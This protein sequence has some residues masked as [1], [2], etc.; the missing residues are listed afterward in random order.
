M[1]PTQCPFRTA[2]VLVA[3]AASAVGA[4]A[5]G[6]GETSWK[7]GTSYGEVA[8]GRSHFGTSCGV[9]AGLTCKNAGIAY[10]LR[11]GDMFSTYFGAEL[12]FLD[13]GHADR[14]GGTV[15]ARA[16]DLALVGR[17]PVT[18][19]LELTGKVGGTWGVTHVSASTA[20]GLATTGRA[21]GWGV[22]YGLGLNYNV[23]RTVSASLEWQRH[24]L[25]FAGQGNQPVSMITAGLGWRF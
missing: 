5:Q 13:F 3:V 8:V 10:S 12:S 21:S 9:V 19:H 18:D 23:S 4:Q 15:S 16:G 17:M 24:D 20:A 25:H 6:L 11:A 7:S 14:A 1:S 22:G 2:L